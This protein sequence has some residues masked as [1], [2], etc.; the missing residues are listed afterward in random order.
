M[1]RVTGGSTGAENESDRG[2]GA[3]GCTLA[4]RG[5]DWRARS[6]MGGR[7]P[8]ARSL[9]WTVSHPLAATKTGHTV[10]TD[11]HPDLDAEQQHI[12]FAYAC[13]EL[14]RERAASLTSMVEVG[15]GGTN[16]ARFERDAIF[17]GVLSRLTQLD[18]GDRSI[19][20]G[21]IDPAGT[22]ERFHIGRLG[23]ELGKP[24]P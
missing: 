1:P 23:V 20:F 24:H 2:H 3:D 19:V 7:Q 11:R 17:E 15:Q 21:R 8:P 18:V 12:D 13:L 9:G 10:V 4:G 14:A 5:G 16:Q 22:G 6:G